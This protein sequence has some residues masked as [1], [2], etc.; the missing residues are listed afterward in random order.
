VSSIRDGAECL[1]IPFKGMSLVRDFFGY[2]ARGHTGKFSLRKQLQ[3]VAG[4]HV[5]LNLI[6]VGAENFTTPDLRGI[7]EALELMR[8]IYAQVN[9]GVGRVSHFQVPEAAAQE[10]SIFNSTIIWDPMVVWL[11]NAWTV[12]N[13]GLDVFIVLSWLGDTLGKSPQGGSCDKDDACDATGSVVSIE[14]DPV[15]SG[16]VMAHEVG[17][18]LGLPH[19]IEAWM[20]DL[21]HDGFVDPTVP[22]ELT[23]NLMF[24][25]AALTAQT[26]T[27]LQG[28]R[29]LL[30]CFMHNC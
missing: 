5:N 27:P 25:G 29:M 26:L 28:G 12:H 15:T 14:N 13:D 4:P 1:G 6:R 16:I 17:H 10:S 19:V 18:Y 20:V 2:R 23:S 24:P 30:H 21:D 3:L 8:T 7:D 9:I 11:T 22:A